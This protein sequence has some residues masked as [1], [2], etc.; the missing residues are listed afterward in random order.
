MP[1]IKD[2]LSCSVSVLYCAIACT[3]QFR[4]IIKMRP[5]GIKCR[6]ATT[7]LNKNDLYSSSMHHITSLIQATDKHAIS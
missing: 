1:T 4:S 6:I 3:M 5:D 2:T 7:G